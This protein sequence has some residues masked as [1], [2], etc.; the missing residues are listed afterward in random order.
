M[1]VLL[2]SVPP[3]IM[4]AAYL[5][6][7]LDYDGTLAEFAPNPDVLLPDPELIQLL[8]RIARRNN[9]YLAIISGRR[10]AH[11]QELIP[12]QGVWLAGTYGIELLTP[13]GAKI[14]RLDFSTIRPVLQQIK[15]EIE[16]L[17]KEKD[18]FY[19]E[20]KGWSLAIHAR[21]ADARQADEVLST[22]REI[23]ISHAS[24]P[25]YHLLGG[26]KF[27]EISP[28]KADKGMAVAYLLEKNP[29]PG[30]MIVYAGD[31]DKDE[32]AYKVIKAQGGIT[33]I[34]SKTPRATLADF[35]LT[36]PQHLRQVLSS[37]V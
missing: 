4:E 22:A 17:L 6:L 36:S 19:L 30:A 10:L 11:V 28:R 3:S 13:T 25:E 33:L 31:D 16:M 18:G 8:E 14:D 21:F 23:M 9:T 29:L 35:R 2:E 27:L 12:I 37:L 24:S 1:T 34:V 32:Q 20:D 15:P 7:F 5:W 26:D